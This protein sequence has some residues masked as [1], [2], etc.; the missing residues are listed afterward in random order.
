MNCQRQI[1]LCAVPAEAPTKAL[2]KVAEKPQPVQTQTSPTKDLK[3][4]TTASLPTNIVTK[5]LPDVKKDTIAKAPAAPPSKTL[6]GFSFDAAAPHY[7]AVVLNKVDNIFV[8][9]ARNA[10]AR[11]SREKY[12]NQQAPPVQIINLNADVKLL[13]IGTFSNADQSVAFVQNAKEISSTQ[14]VPWLK[15]DKYYFT[16]LSEANLQ[17]LQQ[18]PDMLLYNEFL[19]VNTSVKF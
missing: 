8:N 14:I 18:T 11:Y 6:N 7:A 2:E 15:A 16:I 12:F 17:K 4:D 9:E 19:K 13:L 5:K 3:K 1:P 10:F